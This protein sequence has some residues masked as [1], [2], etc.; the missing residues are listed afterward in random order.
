MAEVTIF[1]FIFYFFLVMLG[2]WTQ[3]LCTCW[4]DILPL[5]YFL[6]PKYYYYFFLLWLYWAWT[7]N[8]LLEPHNHFKPEWPGP[9]PIA[10]LMREICP[11]VRKCGPQKWPRGE[12]WSGQVILYCRVGEGESR[13]PREKGREICIGDLI[14]F[15]FFYRKGLL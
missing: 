13:E 15:F 3:G 9:E 6:S 2:N 12:E 7:Q 5:S 4:A 8:F 14:F 10:F 1:Y 11:N